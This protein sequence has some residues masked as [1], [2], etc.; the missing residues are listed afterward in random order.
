MKKD[1]QLGYEDRYQIHALVKRGLSH[2]DIAWDIAVH[3]TTIWRELRR[4][5]GTTGYY[6]H[7]AQAQAEQRQ[8]KR[9]CYKSSPCV[10]SD[11]SRHGEGSR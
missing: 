4:N 3:R 6:Y 7:W 5:G 8:R 11:G 9:R 10:C 2:S 1:R